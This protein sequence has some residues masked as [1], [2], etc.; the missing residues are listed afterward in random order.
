MLF[1]IYLHIILSALTVPLMAPLVPF[2]HGP[3]VIYTFQT[4]KSTSISDLFRLNPNPFWFQNMVCKIK[5]ISL[6][7]PSGGGP[8][9]QPL[10]FERQI[11]KSRFANYFLVKVW[12]MGLLLLHLPSSSVSQSDP[13]DNRAQNL[14]SAKNNNNTDTF[15]KPVRERPKKQTDWPCARKWFLSAHNKGHIFPPCSFAPSPW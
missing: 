8:T 12:S 3:L 13:L 2:I 14:D 6:F 4:L 7:P 1:S 9:W 5:Y 11:M 10:Q 15:L